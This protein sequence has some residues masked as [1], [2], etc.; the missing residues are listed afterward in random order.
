MAQGSKLAKPVTNHSLRAYVVTKMF[1]SNVPEK[2][3]MERSGHRSIDGLRQ[4]ERTSALQE[5]QVCNALQSQK[6]DTE[7][8]PVVAQPV[9]GPLSLPSF[10]RCTF[11]NCTF[12]VATPVQ[13][14][15]QP[16]VQT[17]FQAEVDY[18]SKINIQEFFQ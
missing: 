18:L 14:K 3:I 8:A 16:P 5:L 7:K 2:L 17:A 1:A 12:Q 6:E 4:H 15:F 11:N 9:A 13:A 10:S